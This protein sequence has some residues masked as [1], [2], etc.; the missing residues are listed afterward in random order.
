MC[1]K[2]IGLLFLIAFSELS[3]GR[4]LSNEEFLNLITKQESVKPKS[5]VDTEIGY[6]V[7]LIQHEICK[8]WKEPNIGLLIVH[9]VVSVEL[10]NNYELVNVSITESSGIKSFDDSVIEAVEAS[11]PFG[12]LSG[13]STVKYN[14]NFKKFKLS[15][16]PS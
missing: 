2:V 12:I 5:E 3:Y 8:A 1:K 10:N 16:A 13:L 11:T 7:S 6:F 14:N 4:E 9:T 15:F